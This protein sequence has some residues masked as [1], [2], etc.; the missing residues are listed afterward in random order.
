MGTTDGVVGSVT[1]DTKTSVLL[2]S[3]GKTTA[4]TVLVDRVDDPVD[5]RIVADGNV[6][7][8]D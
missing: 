3:G 6:V 1:L 7:R 2:T 8:I 5:A 4:F